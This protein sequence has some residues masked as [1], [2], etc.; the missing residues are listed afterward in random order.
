MS[1]PDFYSSS[2]QFTRALNRDWRLHSIE[3]LCGVLYPV[4]GFYV[5]HRVGLSQVHSVVVPFLIF[6]P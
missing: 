4:V 2:R 5:G 6:G 1:T 3:L